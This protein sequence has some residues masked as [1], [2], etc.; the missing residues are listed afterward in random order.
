[1]KTIKAQKLT[2]ILEKTRGLIGKKITGAI[3]FQTRWGIHTV[4]LFEPIDVIILDNDMK[5]ICVKNSLK[6]NRLYFWNPRYKNI[7]EAPSGY[8]QKN[9]ITV[10]ERIRF[11]N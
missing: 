11:E 10:G 9:A 6:P 8:A 2:G 4:G 7:I 5:V 1:M 3:W